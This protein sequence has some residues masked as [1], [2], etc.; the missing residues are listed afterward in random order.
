MDQSKILIIGAN[1]QLGS[2][3]KLKYPG[4]QAVDK[5]ELDITNPEQLKSFDWTDVETIINAA[6][7]TNVD[8]AE[9][10]EGR[11]L[12]WL[13]NAS[14]S[15]LIAKIANTHDITMVHI[16]SEYVFDGEQQ[17][18][19]ED[20]GLSPLGVYAQSKAAGD[21]AVTVAAKH[22]ILRTSWLIGNG[23]N[24]VRTMVGLADKD[25]SPKVVNDQIGRLTFTSTLVDTIDH[26]LGQ[27]AD[28]G[29]YNIS[30]DGPPVS[31]AEITRTIFNVLDR[32]D[33]T[34]TDVSTEEYYASKDNIAPRPLNS[35]F[36]LSKIKATGFTPS[37][38]Q[39]NLVEYINN[40]NKQPSQVDDEQGAN[41]K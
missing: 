1:G 27:K 3:L 10:S 37:N 17:E 34:V 41:E 39:D 28:Y 15:G 16:S 4:A 30:N 26:L 22:Y 5:D 7:Y 11:R 29:T 2:A 31:W 12:A 32:K 35:T 14:A 36:D 25:I 21:I 6:A 19:T 40:D 9:T 18:H 8:G 38:W 33:L 13:I 24:F 23:P 20:E